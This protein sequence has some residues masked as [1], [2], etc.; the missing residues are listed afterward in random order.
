[1]NYVSTIGFFD[2]VHRGHQYLLRQ[3]LDEG[4]RRGLA[5]R[6]YT[7][8]EHPRRVLQADY[9][10]QLLTTLEEK[11]AFIAAEG[12]DEC[13]V[14]EF[15]NQMARM[16]AAQFMQQ[17]LIPEGVKVLLMGYDHRFGSDRADFQV[18]RGLGEALGVEILQELPFSENAPQAISS[19]LVR[20][21]LRSGDVAAATCALGRYYSLSGTVGSGR[22][23]GRDLGF[24]T[25][26]LLPDNAQKMLPAAGAYAVWA[27]VDG[28]K[29][30]GMTN[31]GT[32]PTLQ[33][34][35]DVTV[36]THILDFQ[37]DIYGHALRLEF[38]ERLRGEC[39]FAALDALR[40]QLHDDALRAKEI[41]NKQK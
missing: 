13:R 7:F 6:V 40:A 38:V 18:C 1:M 16:T 17:I 11:R 9:Q 24:P 10:P 2:G 39:Q 15:D 32:R 5:T 29:Y 33:N 26:N 12:I 20:R 35:E 14:L 3:L 19:S 27:H 31:I 4:K 25:A 22:R 8:A 41:L 28:K 36:E 37:G 21:E 34:G 30:A 23:V